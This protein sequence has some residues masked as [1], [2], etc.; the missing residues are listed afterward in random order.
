MHR[1]VFVIR[2]Y[3]LV[4]TLVVSSARQRSSWLAG[5]SCGL[6]RSP[7]T[8]QP[9]PERYRQADL[10]MLPLRVVA[11]RVLVVVSC[12]FKCQIGTGLTQRDLRV[13]RNTQS[14]KIKCRFVHQIQPVYQAWPVR[15]SDS[16][17]RHVRCP[18]LHVGIETVFQKPFIS[19]PL[20]RR[21]PLVPTLF[22]MTRVWQI[23]TCLVGNWA[24]LLKLAVRYCVSLI[25]LVAALHMSEDN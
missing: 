17:R 12:S 3:A 15:V 20:T 11:V 24:T 5:V 23:V 10:S 18:D 16:E 7:S 2:S 19:Q 14:L 9:F 6:M 8:C 4:P 1:I 21:R 13:T 22:A 25:L